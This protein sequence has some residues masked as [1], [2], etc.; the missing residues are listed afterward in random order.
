MNT[1]DGFR[2]QPAGASETK[3][4]PA[5]GRPSQDGQG[6]HPTPRYLG[7]L[8]RLQS[9]YPVRLGRNPVAMAMMASIVTTRMA[10]ANIS[11]SFGMAQFPR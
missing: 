5:P 4:R 9:A 7:I 3:R 2:R 6:R 8:S 11:I 1:P 10:A